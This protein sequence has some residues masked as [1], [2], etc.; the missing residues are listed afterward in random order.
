MIHM[1]YSNDIRGGGLK[2]LPSRSISGP[3]ETTMA[4][5]EYSIFL[6]MNE[7]TWPVIV[8][9][10]V[11]GVGSP[12]TAQNC[13]FHSS[14]VAENSQLINIHNIQERMLLLVMEN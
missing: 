9:H 3:Y 2:Y 14:K 4:Q 1:A 8:I 6:L 10:P 12:I 7:C 5:L 13:I 11:A